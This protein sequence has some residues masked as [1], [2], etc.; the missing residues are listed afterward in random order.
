[1][2]SQMNYLPLIEDVVLSD[3]LPLKGICFLPS[4]TDY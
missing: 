1:M 2:R 3:Y 4:K